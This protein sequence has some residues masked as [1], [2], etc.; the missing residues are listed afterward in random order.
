MCGEKVCRASRLFAFFSNC[1]ELLEKASRAR[2]RFRH[3]LDQFFYYR[4]HY[5][6]DQ[7]PNRDYFRELLNPLEEGDVIL[8]FNWDTV[9]ER[10]LGE[11]AR[12][13]PLTGYGIRKDLLVQPHIGFGDPEPLPVDFPISSP[14]RVLKLH[15]SFGWRSNHEDVYF[16]SIRFLHEFGFEYER[17]P[18][19][20]VDPDEP[21]VAMYD[22]HLIAY[23]SY[24]KALD[25][26]VLTEIWRQ[27]SGALLQTDRVDVWGYSLP[28]SDSAARALLQPLAV[29]LARNE[30][31]VAVHDPNQSTLDRWKRFLGDS[32]DTRIESLVGSA[33]C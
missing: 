20:L 5:D 11:E 32:V 24:L 10:T 2:R 25:H 6:R 17:R 21:H 19:N 4:H 7:R 22:D 3:C 30:V 16:E 12:W 29:R 26:P 28:P 23:P 8:T 9:A 31:Q 1:N 33:S 15:G 18:L 27:A 14:I 13:N